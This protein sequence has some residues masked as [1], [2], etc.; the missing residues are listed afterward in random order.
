MRTIVPLAAGWVLTL[1][2]TVGV[3]FS[4]ESVISVVTVV[5]TAAYYTLFRM[6]ERAA[7]TG[8]VAEKIFGALLGYARPPEYPKPVD[9]YR[10]TPVRGPP[11]V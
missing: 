11:V 4:S 8:G 3:D 5:I 2:A 10:V 9:P 1:L 6:L 7:P